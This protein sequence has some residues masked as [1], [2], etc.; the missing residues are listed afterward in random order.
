MLSEHRPKLVGVATC[1]LIKVRSSL[2][3]LG[4][5]S[6]KSG[7]CG[8]SV[9]QSVGQSWRKMSEDRPK[10]GSLARCLSKFGQCWPTLAKF[11]QSSTCG[12]S[13]AKVGESWARVGQNWR[14]WANYWSNFDH[15]SNFDQQLAQIEVDQF[16]SNL[17]RPC[18]YSATFAHLRRTPGSPGVQF[19]ER[20]ASDCSTLYHDRPL[21]RC[22]HLWASVFLGRRNAN[23]FGL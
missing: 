21:Q 4:Q 14:R 19:G 22:R 1:W 9:G 7:R 15:L 23:I 6:T 11:G 10:L 8:P 2:A 16:W 18:N 3:K 17:R 5:S 13:L 12:Q 20:M